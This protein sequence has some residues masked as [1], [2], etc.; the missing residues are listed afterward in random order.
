MGS[1]EI[2]ERS[3]RDGPLHD[4]LEVSVACT[5]QATQAMPDCMVE[6]KLCLHTGMSAKYIGMYANYTQGRTYSKGCMPTIHRDY[7][8]LNA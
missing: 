4:F 6:R 3:F 7:V 8:C 2:R 1:S 5:L